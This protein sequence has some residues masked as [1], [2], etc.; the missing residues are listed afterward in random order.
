M[1]DLDGFLV[2]GDQPGIDEV[3]EHRTG[4][5]GPL[6]LFGAAAFGKGD[7]SPTV[8]GA[9]PEGD[10]SQQHALQRGLARRV[11]SPADTVGSLG[12]GTVDSPV[13][14]YPA[15][16]SRRPSLL[17]HVGP[18]RAGWDNLNCPRSPAE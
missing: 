9:F 13:A 15:T 1:G 5:D 12:D 7:P 14:R 6:A 4:C 2:G 8:R 10:Q 17:R 16:V 18:D 3:S 11:E